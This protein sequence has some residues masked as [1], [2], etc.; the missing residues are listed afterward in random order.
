[1][2]KSG[3]IGKL[4]I[5]AFVVGAAL[6]IIF[7]L[8]QAY[9][10]E[11]TGSFT[12]SFY[13]TDVGGWV[14]WLLALIGIIVGVLAVLGKGTITKQEI[15]DFLMGGMALL[16]MFGVFGSTVELTTHL[17]PYLGG[18]L[19]GLSESLAIFIAPAVGL[20]ALKAVWDIGKSV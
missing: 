19:I 15:P 10:L 12:N 5:W 17:S 1:M 6:A 13:T 7:G 18:L 3:M 14:A 2:E 20:L 11:S 16:I 9:T 8:Y 4:A